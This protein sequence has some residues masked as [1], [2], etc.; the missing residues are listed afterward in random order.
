VYDRTARSFD[1]VRARVC[2]SRRRGR[3]LDGCD[4]SWSGNRARTVYVEVEGLLAHGETGAQYRL[5]LSRGSARR[6]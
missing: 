5:R 1:D 4:L 6:R 3:A 2:R